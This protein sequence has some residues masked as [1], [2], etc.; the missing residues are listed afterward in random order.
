MLLVGFE[1]TRIDTPRLRGEV[2]LVD[3]RGATSRAREDRSAI[4][5]LKETG[6]APWVWEAH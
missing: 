2:C 3:L 5:D 4:A 1:P 6:I